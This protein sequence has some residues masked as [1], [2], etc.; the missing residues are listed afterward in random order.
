MSLQR[1]AGV[2]LLGLLATSAAEAQRVSFS[3]QV[4]PRYEYRD[5]GGD[6]RDEFVSMRVRAGLEAELADDVS[7]FLQ[8]QDVRLWGEETSPLGDFRA[9]AFDLHQGYLVIDRLGGEPLAARVGRQE[10]ALGEERLMGA[11]D[12][13][14]QGQAFDGVRVRFTPDDLEADLFALR[15]GEDSAGEEDGWL[16]GAYTVFD[17]DDAGTLDVYGFLQRIRDLFATDEF[18]VGGRYALDRGRAHARMEAAAQL[19]ERSS[20]DVSAYL[21][22]LAAGLD[23]SDDVR[24]T[25]WYDY[26]SG[27]ADPG[28]D[29]TN[30]FRTLFATN[31]RFYGYADLFLDIPAHTGGRGLQDAAL[32]LAY[33]PSQRTSI[34]LDVHTFRVARRGTLVDAHLGDEVDLTVRHRLRAAL[35]V[36]AGLSHVAQDDALA[37]IGRLDDDLLFGYLM[38]NV[39]F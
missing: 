21:V 28:D 25:L 6:E 39:V 27:D 9:D 23:L 4:R 5:P 38:L 19:G 17:L 34:E 30:V 13:T 8:L 2:L 29:E 18:T 16:L 11:V 24:I 15:T 10:I 31:H 35:G 22:A 37:E 32:K 3:G 26:L 12:W 36:T 33:S 20:A 7:V 1:T 14:P